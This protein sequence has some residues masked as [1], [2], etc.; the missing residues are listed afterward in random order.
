MA[1]SSR[2]FS[3]FKD[4]RAIKTRQANEQ[5]R[6]LFLRTKQ[7]KEF[8]VNSLQVGLT[9]LQVMERVD[10]NHGNGIDSQESCVSWANMQMNYSTLCVENRKN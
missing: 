10:G 4:I 3:I 2:R 6:A 9:Q 8:Q 1:A 5:K 7:K